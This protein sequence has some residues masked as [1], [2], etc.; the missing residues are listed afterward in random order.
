MIHTTIKIL[1]NYHPQIDSNPW[2][3]LC[4]KM[5]SNDP[6]SVA[7]IQACKAASSTVTAC[8]AFR[9]DIPDPFLATTTKVTLPGFGDTNFTLLVSKDVV[10]E[11][12][13]KTFLSDD[14]GQAIFT[15]LTRQRQAGKRQVPLVVHRQGAGRLTCWSQW[16]MCM[17]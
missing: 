7:T 5:R 17:S 10:P 14:G 12:D 1:F 6:T 16:E 8:Q 4:P 2:L 9:L 13:S 11:P 3:F 15:L